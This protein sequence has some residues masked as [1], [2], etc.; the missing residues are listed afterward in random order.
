MCEQEGCRKAMSIVRD[1]QENMVL[2]DKE[3]RRHVDTGAGPSNPASSNG[4]LVKNWFKNTPM[5]K[6]WR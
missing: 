4:Q 1:L 3:M 6:W 2:S 5:S